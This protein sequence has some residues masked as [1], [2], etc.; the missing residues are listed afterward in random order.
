VLTGG[1]VA[2]WE[3]RCG[4]VNRYAMLAS[5]DPEDIRAGMFSADGKAQDWKHAP[6]VEFIVEPRAKTQKPHADVIAFVPGAL[7]L[8][9]RACVVLA[10]FFSRFGQLLELHCPGESL[11]FY[12]VTNLVDCVDVERSE[13]RR[14]GTIAM[15]AFDESNVPTE[16]AVFKDPRMAAVRIYVNDSGRAEIERVVEAERLAGIECGA[17]RRF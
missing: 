6:V 16:P 10:S 15:E 5:S 7:V 13:K 2:I 12:N 14:S 17:P 3:L 9:R 1:G 8:S 11:T 4:E